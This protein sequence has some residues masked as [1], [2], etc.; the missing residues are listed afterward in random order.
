MSTCILIP[1]RTDSQRLYQK[2][3]IEVGDKPILR[4]TYEQALNAKKRGYVDEVYI[5]A[6]D[7]NIADVAK[8]WTGD[9]I[10][11]RDTESGSH[12]VQ[13]AALQFYDG[14]FD[15]FINWQGDSPDIDVDFIQHLTKD[16]YGISSGYYEVQQPL[17]NNTGKVKVVLDNDDVAMYFSR[18]QIPYHSPVQKIHIGLYCFRTD[19]LDGL[20]LS[21]KA[22]NEE[23]LEQISW[24]ENHHS[25]KMYESRP[26]H[27]IDTIED[28][29]CYR[30]YMNSGCCCKTR[31]KVYNES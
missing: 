24:L 8:Q 22:K 18:A 14:D 17:F 28:L 2:L 30:A 1:A 10:E 26:Y 31:L 15:F 4:H 16:G 7:R 19:I 20:D 9:V 6:A 13:K 5:V 29:E 11:V 25:I 21:A 12:A 23:K 27:G 3:L